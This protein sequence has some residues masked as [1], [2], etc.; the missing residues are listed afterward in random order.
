MARSLDHSCLLCVSVASINRKHEAK[1]LQSLDEAG[2]RKRS[3]L[4]CWFENGF[5]D[6]THESTGD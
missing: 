1:L 4:V 2:S 6:E 3:V 5:L